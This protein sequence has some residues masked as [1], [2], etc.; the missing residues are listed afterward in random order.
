MFQLKINDAFDVSL[1]QE[2]L[3]QKDI[4]ALPNAAYN[5][6]EGDRSYVAQVVAADL[7]SKHVTIDI[8]GQS[9]EVQISDALDQLIQE[10]G[11]TVGSGAAEKEIKAPMPGL[12]LQVMVE[13]GQT[14][15]KGDSLLILEAMKMENVLKATTDGVVQ[16]IKVNQ[17]AAVDKNQVLVELA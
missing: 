16:A 9:Y 5:I 7:Q 4:L 3:A 1:S 10:M 14:I 6:I 15:Q 11:L 13:E 2:A 8:N 17:G 12:V